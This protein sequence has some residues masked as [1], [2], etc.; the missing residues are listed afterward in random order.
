MSDFT[1]NLEGVVEL[2][3]ERLLEQKLAR[4]QLPPNWTRPEFFP[5]P[6]TKLAI[7]HADGSVTREYRPLALL[8][9][10]HCVLEG[11]L[12]GEAIAKRHA[13][14]RAAGETQDEDEL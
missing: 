12:K 10:V 14:R 7:E 11:Q 6:H 3:S 9:Y 5:L 13:E 1:R 2:A 4:I 8:E